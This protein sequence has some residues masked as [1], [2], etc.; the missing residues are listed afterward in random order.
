MWKYDPANDYE[1]LVERRALQVL[2]DK[3]QLASFKS[4]LDQAL[5]KL[6]Q[7]Q[8]NQKVVNISVC[9]LITGAINEIFRTLVH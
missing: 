2:L 6:E 1:F 5:R 4:I 7:R 3:N 9:A 8:Q